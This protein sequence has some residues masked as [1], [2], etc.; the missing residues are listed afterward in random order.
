MAGLSRDGIRA[1]WRFVRT[2]RAALK[3]VLLDEGAFV[4]QM[5]PLSSPMLED[6]A[7]GLAFNLERPW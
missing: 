7:N 4:P 2:G 3:D 6:Q 5:D 1:T